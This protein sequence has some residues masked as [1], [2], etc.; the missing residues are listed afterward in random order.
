MPQGHF[1][2]Y[3]C[4]HPSRHLSGF[5]WAITS[6]FVDGFQNDLAQM[7]SNTIRVFNNPK[8]GGF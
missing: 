2:V 4:V 1:S 8:E 7:F 6:V 3:A 5:V